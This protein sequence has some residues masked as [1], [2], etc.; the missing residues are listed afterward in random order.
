MAAAGGRI[1]SYTAAMSRPQYY[2]AGGMPSVTAPMSVLNR[3][4]SADSQTNEALQVLTDLEDVRAATLR[5]MG[6]AERLLSIFTSDLEPKLYDDSRFLDR[7]QKF[8]LSHSYAKIRV[9]THK[10]IPYNSPLQLAALRR[11]LSGHVDIRTLH[12]QFA[13][14]VSAMLIADSKAI[15]YRARAANWEGVAGFADPPVARL[16]LQEFDEMWL[17][18]VPKY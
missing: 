8:L 16:Y 13:A 3:L 12:T 17:A 6:K 15:V 5:A 2:F 9:L 10:P 1:A 7:I 14:R 18:S 4:G 11:R